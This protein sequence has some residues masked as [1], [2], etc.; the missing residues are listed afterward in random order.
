MLSF[1]EKYTNKG[2]FIFKIGDRLVDHCRNI[3]NESGVYLIYTIKN[4]LEELVYIGASG[5]MKQNGTFGVQ[6]LH[7]RIQNMQNSKLTRQQHFEQEIVANKIDAIKVV[8]FATF[9]D[10][11]KDLPMYVEALLLQSFFEKHNKLPRWNKQA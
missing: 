6:K 2:E 3:P 8:W 1:L 9:D 10:S 7:K 5:K 11:F 4:N